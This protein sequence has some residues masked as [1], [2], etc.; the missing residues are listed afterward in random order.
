MWGHFSEGIYCCFEQ[1]KCED[2]VVLPSCL[3]LLSK[4]SKAACIIFYIP[5]RN[6]SWKPCNRASEVFNQRQSGGTGES[7]K[8]TLMAFPLSSNVIQ[9]YRE[10]LV[11]P[12]IVKA[13]IPDLS[14]T[15]SYSLRKSVEKG[16]VCNNELRGP[17]C[18]GVIAMNSYSPESRNLFVLEKG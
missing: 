13:S 3:Q 9:Q 6:Q 16:W 2:E 12:V 17:P 15:L 11:F 18:P 4:A 10:K 1:Q 8:N 7:S 14:A 5:T